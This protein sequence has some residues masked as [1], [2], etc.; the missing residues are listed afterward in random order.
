MVD[1]KNTVAHLLPSIRQTHL[2]VN[3]SFSYLIL[4]SFTTEHENSC[5]QLKQ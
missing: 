3:C 2:R 5:I 1:A 4:F